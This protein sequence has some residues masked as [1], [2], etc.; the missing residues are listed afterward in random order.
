MRHSRSPTG[1]RGPTR[2]APTCSS[3]STPTRRRAAVSTASRPTIWTTPT[4]T[5][6]CGSRRWRT[7]SISSRRRLG[8]RT[9]V[10]FSATSCRWGRWTSRSRSRRPCS[11]SSS[12]SSPH[13][14]RASPTSASNARRSTSSSALTC[15]ACSWRRRSL[16]TRATAAGS[17]PRA[18]APRSPK[19]STA[20]S[21]A[22][23][24]TRAAPRRCERRQARR[25]L[26]RDWRPGYGRRGMTLADTPPFAPLE[27]VRTLPEETGDITTAGATAREYLGRVQAEVRA[28]H[29]AGAGGLEL[30]AA[31]TDAI[32]RLVRL[33]FADASRHYLERHPRINQ[34]CVLIALGGY[35]RGE[36]NPH[37]DIDLLFLYPWKVNPYIETVAEVLLYALWDA[38][39][40]VGHALRNT[41]ECGHLAAGD[42]KVK[43]A[44]LDARYVWGDEPLYAEFTDIMHDEVWSRDSTR[45]FKE[46]LAESIER[47]QRAG[48]SVYLL[49][50]QLK[51]GQ[52]GLRDLHTAL[53][54]AKVKFKVRTFREL[55]PLGVIGE[56]SVVELE[57]ALDFLWRLR[58]AMHLASNNAH[59]DLLTFELQERLAPTLGFAPGRPGVEAFMRAYYGHATTVNRFSDTVIARCVQPTEPYRGAQ[60]TRVIRDGMRIQGRTLSVAGRDVFERNP[61]ALVHVFAEAQRH[62]VTIA[63]ATRELIRD[64]LDLIGPH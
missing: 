61:A 54:M 35:G 30:V 53:W 41:R 62:G 2:K 1:R 37:S 59:Q 57:G 8:R 36:L 40:A 26:E 18:T 15:R 27:S 32:D 21:S 9:S 58:N 60:P 25:V 50:P 51:E 17:R 6:A 23:S 52:G 33:L 46:K 12:G 45:F 56:P 49:Q 22:F 48:D 64:S 44:V 16:P 34:R 7:A 13:A 19:A 24:P 4:T 3:R 47:H 10:T 63:P 28:R 43:T 11:G 31:Y 55:I 14:I 38:G 39:L 29:E 42:M 5:R 20:A